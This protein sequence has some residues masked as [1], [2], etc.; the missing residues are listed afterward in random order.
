MKETIII[1]DNIRSVHNVGSIFRTSDALGV[2]KIFLC[3]CT[4]TPKDRFGRERKDLAK[5]ALGAEKSI[6]WEYFKTTEEAVKK[7]KKEKFQIIALEQSENS[8][9]YKKVKTKNK[10][11]IILGEEVHGLNKKVLDLTDII[12]EIPMRGVK[13]SLN[14]SVSFGVAAF[15][16]FNI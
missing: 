5:V 16:I 15:R 1:L 4:P 11:A 7:L 14:V 9:D 10:T 13:E 12:M 2:N 6:E 3:G 8:I